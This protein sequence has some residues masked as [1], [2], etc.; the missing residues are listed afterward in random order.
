MFL[1]KG[2]VTRKQYETNT[3]SWFPGTLLYLCGNQRFYGRSVRT[4][5][6]EIMCYSHGHGGGSANWM[7]CVFY[8]NEQAKY[9]LSTINT[10]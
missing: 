8:V 5:K 9:C 1:E 3:T 6:R 4:T 7:R 10:P 2:S